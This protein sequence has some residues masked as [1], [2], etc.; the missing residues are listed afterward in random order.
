MKFSVTEFGAIVGT[1]VRNG[2]FE[3]IFNHHNPLVEVIKSVTL[4]LNEYDPSETREIIKDGYKVFV[5]VD[6]FCDWSNEI[7]IY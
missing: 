2:L 4:I 3:C 1:Y 5:I 7:H 6:G